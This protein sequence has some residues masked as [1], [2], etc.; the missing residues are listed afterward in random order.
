M[1]F[2]LVKAIKS[3]HRHPIN[4]VLHC[5]GF[6]IYV[7]GIALILGDLFGLHTN[8]VNGVILWSMA[9]GL[10]LLGHG[11]E[12]NLRAMT[13]IVIFKYVLRSSRLTTAVVHRNVSN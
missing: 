2:S 6:P 4:R 10:F 5:I 8:P 13:L 11:I 12:S 3:S 7:T 9:I 1:P